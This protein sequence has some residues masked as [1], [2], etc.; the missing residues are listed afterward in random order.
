MEAA[1]LAQT[2]QL[3]STSLAYPGCQPWLKRLGQSLRVVTVAVKQQI[4]DQKPQ[5]GQ[6]WRGGGICGLIT[7]AS[8]ELR[9]GTLNKHV[10]INS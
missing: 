7:I 4:L 8:P 9:A 3:P 10:W 1:A 2:F 6:G 5:K